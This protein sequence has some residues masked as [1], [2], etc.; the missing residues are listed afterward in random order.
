MMNMPSAPQK[1]KKLKRYQKQSKLFGIL[2][3]VS[4]FV[5]I[6]VVLSAIKVTIY[7]TYISQ[8]HQ[9]KV[10]YP[11]HWRL[12]ENPSGEGIVA[13][14]APK[15]YE[16]D[17]F[18]ESVNITTQPVQTT[19]SL[20]RITEKI[21]MQI[22]GTFENNVEILV[23]D[24]TYVKNFSAYKFAYTTNDD[25]IE[26]PIQYMH[27]WFV[28]NNEIFIITYAAQQDDWDTYMKYFTAIVKS[29]RVLSPQEISELK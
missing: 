6:I 28:V 11:T 29:F 4:I 27:V 5:I 3:F 8:E 18:Q 21:I 26:N 19:S 1:P 16:L 12:I 7:E 25:S 20:P 10:K 15:T 9:F 22:I 13:F 2:I 24:R 23:S 17:L 14:L